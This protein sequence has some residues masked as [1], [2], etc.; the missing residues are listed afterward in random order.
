MTDAFN[1]DYI[2]ALASKRKVAIKQLLMNAHVVVGVGNIYAN[3]VLFHTG[4][5]PTHPANTIKKAKFVILVA[6]IKQIL[7]AAIKQGGTTLKD[8]QQTD[9]KPGYFAQQLQVYGR[10]GQACTKCK[11]TL[12]EIRQSGRTT[13][14]CAQ[15]Q[16]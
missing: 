11:S 9:G 3:E 16:K 6:A 8:F 4:I 14:F 5:L 12:Q 2:F 10:R 7:N 15:C 1:V 13:V